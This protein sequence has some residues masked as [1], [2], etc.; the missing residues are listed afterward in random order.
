[1]LFSLKKGFIAPLVVLT[2]F[3][4]I[5]IAGPIF[6]WRMQLGKGISNLPE[7]TPSPT[8]L[9]TSN[10][11]TYTNSIYSFKYPPEWTLKEIDRSNISLE[12]LGVLEDNEPYQY[13]INFETKYNQNN[14]S[15]ERFLFGDGPVTEEMRGKVIEKSINGNNVYESP[16]TSGWPGTLFDVT[17]DGSIYVGILN[18]NDSPRSTIDVS[19]II[20][21]ILSTF[22]F[23]N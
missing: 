9:D 12:Y 16:F 15:Y 21:S 4:I 6:Y 23:T 10:W 22:K 7:P 1:M 13:G 14:L 3:L 17:K 18:Q 11:K 20:Y 8:V 19:S 5:A 2:I